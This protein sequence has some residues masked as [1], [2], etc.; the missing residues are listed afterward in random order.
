MPLF[1]NY[2]QWVRIRTPGRSKVTSS[3]ISS[4]ITCSDKIPTAIPMFLISE[5]SMAIVQIEVDVSESQKF[6]MAVRKPEIVITPLV[7]WKE[8]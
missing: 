1:I 4:S 7:L 3:I 5:N 8:M 2:F 6:N